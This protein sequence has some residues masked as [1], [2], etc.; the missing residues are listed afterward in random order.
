VRLSGGELCT[1]ATR[2]SHVGVFSPLLANVYM[3]DLDQARE[4]P[5][6]EATKPSVTTESTACC[7]R[8]R[9]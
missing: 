3:N 9:L 5:L 8:S 4:R 2:A 1:L 7:G 6:A